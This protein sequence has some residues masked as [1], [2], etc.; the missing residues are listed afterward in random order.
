MVK[1]TNKYYARSLNTEQ[2]NVGVFGRDHCLIRWDTGDGIN[3][4][5]LWEKPYVHTSFNS[6]IILENKE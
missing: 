1:N 3:S 2:K 5:F 6:Q 4:S